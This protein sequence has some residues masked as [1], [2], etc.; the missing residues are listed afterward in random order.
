MAWVLYGVRWMVWAGGTI[1]RGFRSCPA[2]VQIVVDGP[3]PT[4][5]PPRGPFW[6][7]FLMPRPQLS[8]QGLETRVRRLER[9]TRV[10]GVLLHLRP[11]PLAPAQVA[12]LTGLVSRLRSADKRVVCW[13]TGY[14]A[15]TYQVACAADEVLV[16]PG[17]GIGQL[18]PA[19]SYLFLRE[20]LDRVG[21]EPDFI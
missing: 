18:G 13:A 21:V 7:R 10:R 8:F 9:E 6:R 2:W 1:V 5:D 14:T 11:V 12:A 19:R 4:F 17:G 3:L 16:Q 15:G 20:T